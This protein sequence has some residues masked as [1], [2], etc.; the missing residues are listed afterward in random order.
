MNIIAGI[1]ITINILNIA[2]FEIKN[3]GNNQVATIDLLQEKTSNIKDN[4]T[5]P[6]IY[7]ILLDE[8]AS[9]DTIKEI[10]HH[11]NSPLENFLREKNFFI[12]TKSKTDSSN[13]WHVLPERLNMME[14]EKN[15]PTKKVFNLV[16]NNKAA[17]YLKSKG[18][19]YVYISD[20]QINDGQYINP[21]SDVNLTDLE[22]KSKYIGIKASSFESML[23]ET[24]ILR[25]YYYKRI[26]NG[27]IHQKKELLKIDA[28][29]K[30][31]DIQA[32]KFVFSHHLISHA[33]FPFGENGEIVEKKDQ[34]DWQ[35]KNIYLGTYIFTENQII[36]LVSE[37]LAKSKT[38]PIIIIQ[39]DHGPRGG[40]GKNDNPKKLN[41]GYEW[42]KVFNAYYFPDQNYKE[43]S[44]S[45]DPI[46]TFPII[47]NQYFNED[48][49]LIK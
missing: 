39:S 4:S 6:D 1:L 16:L 32:P 46:N 2:I 36:D 34:Y 31:I 30:A 38:P 18:Y 43:L 13:T 35:N 33:P 8:F 27:E 19:K 42:S 9:L 14:I 48:F 20:R 3:I 23:I 47:F 15:L 26:E 28:V 12:A 10:Y 25:M 21:Y 44:D 11:V 24:S 7:F 22:P 37:I 5:S 17:K 49:K 45:I 41:M 40:Q 29:K